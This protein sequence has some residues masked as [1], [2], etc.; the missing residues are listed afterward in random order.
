MCGGGNSGGG[1]YYQSPP[2]HTIELEQMRQAEAQRQ[3]EADAEK[4]RLDREFQAQQEEL[5]QAAARSLYEQQKRDA[6]EAA[7]KAEEQRKAAQQ[8]QWDHEAAV[9]KAQQDREDAL[10][11][12]EEKKVADA[13]AAEE[14]A[15]R[16]KQAQFSDGVSAG[17]TAL[18]A[19]GM[20]ILNQRGLDQGKYGNLV[21]DAVNS[22]AARVPNLDPN[23]GNYFTD[24]IVLNALSNAENQRRIANT[25]AVNSTFGAGFDKGLIADTADDSYINDILNTQQASAKQSLDFAKARG[26]INDMGYNAGLSALDTQARAARSTLDRLGSGILD[27]DRARL[28]AIKGD[29]LN[30][31]NSWSL[32]SADFSPNAF[33]QNATEQAK[34]DLGNLGGDLSAALGSTQLFNVNDILLSGAKAQGPA[35]GVG[36]T[37]QTAG[38]PGGNQLTTDTKRGLGTSGVF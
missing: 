1:Q 13:K 11:A 19:R 18:T 37:A 4:A 7:A 38:S 9:L 21:T 14:Q 16:M 35:N 34:K 8:A 24:D 10:R 22:A 23:P 26:T 20:N 29:A 17:R 25:T 30:S 27:T 15:Q 5:R 3:R 28:N 32:G 12:A 33:Y 36:T 6:A 2:D 31:A